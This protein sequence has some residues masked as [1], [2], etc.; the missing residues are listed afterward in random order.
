MKKALAAV[1][2]LIAVGV[3][4][5]VGNISQNGITNCENVKLLDLGGI[6]SCAGKDG[7]QFLQSFQ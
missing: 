6:L 1:V 5:V 3:I 4:G 2:L 7:S